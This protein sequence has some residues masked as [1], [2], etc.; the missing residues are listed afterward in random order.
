MAANPRTANVANAYPV[1]T[2]RHSPL[3][4]RSANHVRSVN[5]KGPETLLIDANK[6]H[7]VMTYGTIY[8]ALSHI[9]IGVCRSPAR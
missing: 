1:H 5:A 3:S 9:C 8:G 4:E 6:N 7:I 2:A